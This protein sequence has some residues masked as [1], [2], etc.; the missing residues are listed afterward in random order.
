MTLSGGRLG[1]AKYGEIRWLLGLFKI[2]DVKIT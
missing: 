2:T 1:V